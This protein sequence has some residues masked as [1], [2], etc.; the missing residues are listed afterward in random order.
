MP[1]IKLNTSRNIEKE[2][3]NDLA[4]KLSQIV[5]NATGKPEAYTMAIVECNSCIVF[6]GGQTDGAFVEVKGIGGLAPDVNKKISSS[7]CSLLE[8]EAAIKPEHVYMNF[9]DVPAVNWG[10]NG[11]TFG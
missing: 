4:K 5:C 6:G 8:K 9:T 2:K 1:L 10:W 11:G 7:V 3:R